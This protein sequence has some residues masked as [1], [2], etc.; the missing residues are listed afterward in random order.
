MTK[1]QITKKLEEIGACWA[2]KAE[3]YTAVDDYTMAV[4]WFVKPTWHI[5][6][7]CTYPHTDNIKRFKTLQELSDWIDERKQSMF[8]EFAE[9]EY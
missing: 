3:K 7:D 8:T 4:S 1:K 9:I 5:H 6:P 2:V